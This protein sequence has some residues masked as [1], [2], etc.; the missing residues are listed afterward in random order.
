MKTR[1]TAGTN[2]PASIVLTLA[3]SAL[4]AL[5]SFWLL[6]RLLLD[7]G[8]RAGLPGGGIL[9]SIFLVHALALFGLL[10]R[11]S[12]ARTWSAGVWVGWSLLMALQT[13]DH[14]S[15]VRPLPLGE[16]ALAAFAAVAAG[17]L[18]W[19]LQ[20]GGAAKGYVDR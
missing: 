16:L 19:R 2:W 15:R 20:F 9:L 13:V 12:W 3:A 4:V 1:R 17:M 11:L 8:Y 14:L 5:G 6:V 7:A 10:A 18:A